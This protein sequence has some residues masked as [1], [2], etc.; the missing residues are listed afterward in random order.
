MSKKTKKAA[1]AV[2][3]QPEVDIICPATDESIIY[4]IHVAK[5]QKDIAVNT[6]TMTPA[7]KSFIFNH[8][9]KQLINDSHSGEKDLEKVEQKVMAKIANLHNNLLS[10]RASG[11]DSHG[12]VKKVTYDWLVKSTGN[13]KKA[14]EEFRKINS[15]TTTQLLEIICKQLGED[16]A[17]V[18]AS[19][20]EIVAK[21]VVEASELA[22]NID[23]EEL[24]VQE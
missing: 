12:V 5:L 21:A 3:E 22:A 7:T 1:I 9:L 18:Q 23:L 20:A 19:I 17:V 24:L 2:V 16:I 13:S 10:A 11:D 4:E 8:G 14:L 6:A 15:F